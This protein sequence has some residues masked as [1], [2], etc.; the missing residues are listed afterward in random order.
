MACQKESGA[1][2]FPS[3]H[4]LSDEPDSMRIKV[5]ARYPLKIISNGDLRSDTSVW[6]QYFNS[7]M[8][9]S[10]WFVSYPINN[11]NVTLNIGDY[12][13]KANLIH[14]FKT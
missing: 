10:E 12:I 4:D 9:V 1:I 3:K 5:A 6:N 11:Y 14:N 13:D 8:N 7:W 2:W